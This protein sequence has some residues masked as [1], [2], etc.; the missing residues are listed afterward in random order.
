MNT[1]NLPQAFAYKQDQLLTSLGG[2]QVV[3]HPDN[4]GAISEGSWRT[5]LT[6][7]LPARYQISSAT[8][9]DSRG[10]ASDAI[11]VVIHDRHF[12]PLVFQHSGVTYVPAESVYAVFECKPEVNK[13]YLE[14]ASAKADSVRRLHRTS[15]R[16]VHAGG[17]IATP[18]PPPEILTGLLATHSGWTPGLGGPFSTH[19]VTA[20]SSRLD[21]G[22]VVS[23][24]AWE[25]PTDPTAALMTVASER[26]LVFLAMR[27]LARLQQ[28]GTIPA[29]DFD[30]WSAPLL[31]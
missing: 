7:L 21:L 18:K 27:L 5:M 13:E 29:M 9:V 2:A 16:I 6:D 15:A 4:K 22:C 14:Y 3:G 12:S 31:G 20:G 26:S 23:A 8:V 30:I 17:V 1:F 10:Q 25:V 28:M 11:D 19:L 24:G